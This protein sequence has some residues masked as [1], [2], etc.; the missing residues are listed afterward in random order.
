MIL[1][2][3]YSLMCEVLFSVL[4][5]CGTALELEDKAEGSSMTASRKET[6]LVAFGVRVTIIFAMVAALVT[7]KVLNGV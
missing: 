6:V 2:V 3:L 4:P 5:L 1:T 7:A